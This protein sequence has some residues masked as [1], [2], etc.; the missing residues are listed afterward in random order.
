MA[1]LLLKL[2]LVHD[3][4]LTVRRIRSVTEGN[5][6]MRVKAKVIA[7]VILT[8]TGYK[9]WRNLQANIGTR[10]ISYMPGKVC[11]EREISYQ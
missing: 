9:I 2:K 8:G 5:D 10:R 6:R 1:F 4:V 3:R 7:R 11:L